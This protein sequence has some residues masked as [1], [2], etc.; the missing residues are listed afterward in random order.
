M[1]KVNKK[2]SVGSKNKFIRLEPENLKFVVEQSKKEAR[3]QNNY[4]NYLITQERLKSK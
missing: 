2:K 4:I 3:S 1:K